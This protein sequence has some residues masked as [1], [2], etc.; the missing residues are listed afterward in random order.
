MARTLLVFSVPFERNYIADRATR[1]ADKKVFVTKE[2][3]VGRLSSS[4]LLGFV[5]FGIC[6]RGYFEGNTRLRTRDGIGRRIPSLVFGEGS[7]LFVISLRDYCWSATGS[8]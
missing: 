7:S 3:F 4:S 5:S 6:F 2:L 1:G 8:F